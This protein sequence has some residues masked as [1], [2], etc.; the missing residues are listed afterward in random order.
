M[1]HQAIIQRTTTTSI[2]MLGP[3]EL[4]EMV[5]QHSNWD[6]SS[7]DQDVTCMTWFPASMIQKTF[8]TSLKH[9]ILNCNDSWHHIS[10]L[11]SYS[12]KP[13]AEEIRLWSQS[14]DK[15]MRN[16]AGRNVFRE[17]L[18]TEYSEENMLF[19]L[20]CE[21]LKQEIN[22]NSIEEKARSIYEDYISILSPKEVRDPLAYLTSGVYFGKLRIVDGQIFSNPPDSKSY[23]TVSDCWISG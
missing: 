8:I 10:S 5:D 7:G 17:F 22:K 16:P 3:C 2:H 21:D 9:S 1:M 15:L 11:R 20:A 4:F 14:F 13:S 23:F 19:W 6:S 12:T 18:R